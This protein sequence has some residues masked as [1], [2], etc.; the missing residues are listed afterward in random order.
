MQNAKCKVKNAKCKMQ[1]A[2]CKMQT[3]SGHTWSEARNHDSEA[4]KSFC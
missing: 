1:N 4:V 3:R 2:K